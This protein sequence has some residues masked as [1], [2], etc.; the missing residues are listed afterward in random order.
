MPTRLVIL[1]NHSLFVEGV[2]SSL[3]RQPE[4]VDLQVVDLSQPNVLTEVISARPTVIV[5]DDSYPGALQ[6]LT[7]QRLFQVLP[8]LTI[9]R[10]DH[11]RLQIQVVRCEQLM[12][13]KVRDLVDLIEI[14][15]PKLASKC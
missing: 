13:E 9:I 2:I 11:Q 10:L 5:L 15:I 12:V 4:Q 14:A 7:F 8:E 3:T 6:P 1:T